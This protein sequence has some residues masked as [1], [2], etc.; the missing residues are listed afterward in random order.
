MHETGLELLSVGG[1][2]FALA[3]EGGGAQPLL[4]GDIN[5]GRGQLLKERQSGV[6][7]QQQVWVVSSERYGQVA[8][9]SPA[10]MLPAGRRRQ[11]HR[12]LQKLPMPLVVDPGL[13]HS[14]LKI[15]M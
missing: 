11:V 6:D 5:L 2:K 10:G 14:L 7:S 12:T 3:L 13:S 8:A 9:I 4:R 15:E 1:T